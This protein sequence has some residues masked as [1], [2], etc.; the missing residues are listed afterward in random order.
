[1]NWNA[2]HFSC[3]FLSK[4]LSEGVKAQDAIDILSKDYGNAY[5]DAL[6]RTPVQKELLDST[7][8]TK[9]QELLSIYGNLKLN[10]DTS[11][12]SKLTNVRN[13]LFI[14]FGMFAFLSFIFQTFVIPTFK[15]TFTL[16]SEPLLATQLDIYSKLWIISFVLI[17]LISAAVL[18]VSSII[19][20]L[21]NVFVTTK[22]SLISKLVLSKKV[23][24]HMHK[25][26]A[27]AYAPT[28]KNLNQYSEEEIK[29]VQ[30]LSAD[31][32]NV[33]F[34]I[35]QQLNHRYSALARVINGR[36]KKMMF[37]LSLFLLL[38]IFNFI[39]T[40]YAPLFSVGTAI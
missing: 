1:M 10:W 23:V 17:A 16:I 27:L 32:M 11:L 28:R 2:F 38:A 5:V 30:Q 4:K 24:N 9:L 19:K 35:Q 29:F 14:V 39:Y 7:D 21:D 8:S 6:S 36:I 31:N 37:V 13:Y 18:K 12:I 40:L 3:R 26:Q 22:L 25:T 33:A 20:R 15:E 34:E